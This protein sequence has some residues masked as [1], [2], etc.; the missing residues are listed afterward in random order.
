MVRTATLAVQGGP[1]RGVRQHSEGGSGREG[2]AALAPAAQD[3]QAACRALRGVAGARP[4]AGPTPAA[5]VQR[6]EG[7]G[8][9]R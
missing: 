5:L 3:G 1:Q 4:A 7:D 8:H 2:P 9:R 6:G